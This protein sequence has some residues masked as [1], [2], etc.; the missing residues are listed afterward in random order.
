MGDERWDLLG[1]EKASAYYMR[2]A[3][4][5]TYKLVLKQ[6]SCPLG[7]DPPPPSKVNISTKRSIRLC[8]YDDIVCNDTS[9]K[10]K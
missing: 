1:D 8:C 3:K 9:K 6:R 10:Q 4:Q 2:G 5:S 7:S